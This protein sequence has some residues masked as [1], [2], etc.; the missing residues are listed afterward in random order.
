MSNE[1]I[2]DTENKTEP[3]LWNPNA[4]ALWCLVFSPLFSTWL[5]QRNWQTLGNKQ[6]AKKGWYWLAGLLI[7]YWVI[8]FTGYAEKLGL[9]IIVIWYLGYGR[10]QYRYVKDTL[11]DKYQR[12]PW[13]KVLLCGIGVIAILIIVNAGFPAI[14]DNRSNEIELMAKQTVNEKI[15]PAIRS[16]GRNK[17]LECVEVDLDEEFAHNNYYATAIF[18]NGS[19]IRL[20]VQVKA[21]ETIVQIMNVIEE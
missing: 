11:Q 17:Y 10:K 8:S 13:G 4:A 1:E 14:A 15:L 19:R 2:L 5:I 21:K 12:K 6:E 7:C 18:N 9:P 16:Y 3:E 20:T